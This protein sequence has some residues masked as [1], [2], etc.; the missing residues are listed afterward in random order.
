LRGAMGWS[1]LYITGRSDFREDVL[2]KLEDSGLSFMPGYTGMSSFNAETHELYWID[3]KVKLRQIKEAI[4]SKLIW[5]HRLNF[6]PSLEAFIESQ[7]KK[8]EARFND[9]DLA[10]IEEMKAAVK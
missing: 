3:E 2:D 4:G 10:L 7:N 9:E 5:K 8:K 6:Y 1:T